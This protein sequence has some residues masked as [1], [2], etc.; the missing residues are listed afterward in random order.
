[1]AKK[2]IALLVVLVAVGVFIAWRAYSCFNTPLI[3]FE[4]NIVIPEEVVAD[5]RFVDEH[6]NG[7]TIEL[8]DAIVSI[9]GD[10]I[11]S[12]NFD[13]INEKGLGQLIKYMEE[14]KLAIKPGTYKVFRN[15]DFKELKEA[16]EFY[17]VD[18][19]VV[20]G[21]PGRAGLSAYQA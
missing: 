4:T 21:A 15:A 18:A 14:N 9:Q 3:G 5:T 17:E 11:T 10:G 6:K 2:K 7:E 12:I 20:S 19:S 13:M 8:E 1:M 16:F